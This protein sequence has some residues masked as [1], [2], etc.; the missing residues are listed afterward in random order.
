MPLRINRTLFCVSCAIY[1]K[2]SACMRSKIIVDAQSPPPSSLAGGAFDGFG[3][4]LT[5]RL[6]CV[7]AP[8]SSCEGAGI[9]TS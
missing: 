3:M 9:Q 1:G 4:K 6:V 5:T 8:F 7:P 2:F